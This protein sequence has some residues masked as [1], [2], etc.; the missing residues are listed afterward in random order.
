M[1]FD[2]P[3]AM[4]VSLEVLDVQGRLVSQLAEGEFGPGRHP[5]VWSSATARGRA[6][7]LYFVHLQTTEGRLVR[8]VVVL[9]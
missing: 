3:R 6:A 9:D 1:S 4:H 5:L 2:L 8:R 7:G